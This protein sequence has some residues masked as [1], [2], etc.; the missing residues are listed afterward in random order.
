MAN[1]RRMNNT[2][3]MSIDCRSANRRARQNN[4]SNQSVSPAEEREM[5][6]FKI[7]Q[8]TLAWDVECRRRRLVK[9][10]DSAIRRRDLDGVMRIGTQICSLDAQFCF[11]MQEK[12]YIASR[13]A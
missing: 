9:S 5:L 4:R 6:S 13:R 8:M 2:H 11:G 3:A 10:L 1:E 12:Q 7:N